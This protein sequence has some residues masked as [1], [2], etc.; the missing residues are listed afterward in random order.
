MVKLSSGSS[1][2]TLGRDALLY[3]IVLGAIVRLVVRR[4]PIQRVPAFTGIV[5]AWIA[6]CI[7]QLANPADSS[8]SHA[9]VSLRQHLQFVPLFFLGYLVLRSERR[10]R[11]M[12]LLVVIV[13]AANGVV[14]LIQSGLSPNQLAAWGPGYGILEHGS[15]AHVARV[16]ITTNGQTTTFVRPVSGEPT[17]SAG[18]SA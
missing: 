1:L 10:L 7:L 9:V 12:L 6:L 2:A 3:A 16:F 11:G 4:T 8:L 15:A 18:S 13:A 5:I 17:D 14:D